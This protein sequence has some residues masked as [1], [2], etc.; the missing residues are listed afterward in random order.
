M[1]HAVRA[2]AMQKG[3]SN[4]E[5]SDEWLRRGISALLLGR[6]G[7]EHS[8][9]ADAAGSG[10]G[11]IQQ[12]G[13]SGSRLDWWSAGQSNTIGIIVWSLLA[14]CLYTQF[15]LPTVLIEELPFRVTVDTDVGIE[16]DNVSAPE[17]FWLCFDETFQ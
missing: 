7:I 17:L 5:A 12:Q 1:K 10:R 2:M 16:A 6:V 8:L 13:P 11:K 4:F 15:T 3:K 14:C 9:T